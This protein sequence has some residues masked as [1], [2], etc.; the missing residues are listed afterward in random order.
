MGLTGGSGK[1]LR[2]YENRDWRGDIGTFGEGNGKILGVY[3]NRDWRGDI[4]LVGGGEVA[5]Y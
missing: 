3:E 1:I 4:G 5:R 2:V